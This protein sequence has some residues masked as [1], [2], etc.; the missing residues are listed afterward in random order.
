MT[1]ELKN[2]DMGLEHS[3][4]A[5]TSR[6]GSPF[7][8]FLNDVFEIFL[9]FRVIRLPFSLFVTLDKPINRSVLEYLFQDFDEAGPGNLDD[10]RVKR[11]VVY[12]LMSLQLALQ[13][14]LGECVFDDEVDLISIGLQ[15]GMRE[16]CQESAFP[17]GFDVSTEFQHCLVPQLLDLGHRDLESLA[18]DLISRG[19][20]RRRA[21]VA[22]AIE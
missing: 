5:S 14:V 6:L 8:K 10:L 9:L 4:Y 2:A 12:L 17:L 16:R 15:R 13:P 20:E 19:S 22:M 11:V 21:A 3:D 18:D 1:S 7:R